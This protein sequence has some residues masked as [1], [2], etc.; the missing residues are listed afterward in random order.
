[1]FAQP[2]HRPQDVI[3]GCP[4]LLLLSRGCCWSESA[5]GEGAEVCNF[6]LFFFFFPGAVLK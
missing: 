5:E 4:E 3:L 6:S 2:Q 1:M